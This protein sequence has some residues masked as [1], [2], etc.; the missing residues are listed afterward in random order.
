MGDGTAHLADG[1]GEMIATFVDNRAAGHDDLAISQKLVES[2]APLAIR[3][4]Q[5]ASSG[6]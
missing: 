4:W 2:D 3:Q 5:A 1:E 6:S